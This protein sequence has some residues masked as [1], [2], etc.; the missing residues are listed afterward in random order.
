MKK[1]WKLKYTQIEYT[2]ED[3][4]MEFGIEKCAMLVMKSGKRHLA[5]GMELPN[6]D[7]IRSLE[8]NENYKYLGILEA[9][10]IKQVEMKDKFRKNIVRRTRKLRE[11]KFS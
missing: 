9:D 4:G 3:I 8:E 6:Q 10:T 5:D 2:A 11:T 1:N 7:K